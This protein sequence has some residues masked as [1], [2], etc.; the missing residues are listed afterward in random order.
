MAYRNILALDLATNFGYARLAAG[1]IKYG[2]YRLPSTG[3]DVGRF[4]VAYEEALRG[5]FAPGCDLIIFEA[6]WVGPQTHQNT[7]RK[8]LCLA[9]VTEMV[10]TRLEIA[11]REE[12]NATV[13]KFFIGKG[14]GKRD[15]LK[16]LT[17]DACRARGWN[18]LDDDAADALA[19][20]DY[21]MNLYQVAGAT[22]GPIFRE[23]SR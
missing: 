8:L 12:N 16:R 2:S 19:L 11:C 4:L 6:P 15:E 14:N 20:L 22:A 10:A 21:A 9:G 23:A 5:L 1:E 18:P 17:I 13:R 7:A 3:E